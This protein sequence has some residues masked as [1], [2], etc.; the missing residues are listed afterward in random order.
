MRV[1]QER[2]LAWG[3]KPVGVDIREG[4]G[5]SEDLDVLQAALGHERRDGV[6]AAVDLLGVE[7]REGYRGNARERLEI[8]EELAVVRLGVCRSPVGSGAGSGTGER[9]RHARI[10]GLPLSWAF[11]SE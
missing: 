9:G 5:D 6:R 7:A 8:F 3:V 1:Q 10:I 2:G 4:A 11:A